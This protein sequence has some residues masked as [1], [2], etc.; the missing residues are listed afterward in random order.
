MELSI[1]VPVYNEEKTLPLLLDL[2]VALPVDKEIIT[3]DDGSSDASPMIL[4]Q[5]ADAGKIISLSHPLNRGKGASIITGVAAASGE[6]SVVQD[7]DLEYDPNDLL[8][9]LKVARR[10]KADVVFGSRIHNPQAGIS[11]R[12]YY[13]G[14][15]L[16]TFLANLLFRV[17]IS[18]ESTCYKMVRTDLLK[19]LNLKC[20][21]FEF[22]PE[23]VAKLGRRKVPIIEIPISYRPRKMEEGKKIR[24]HDG[25]VAIW[26]LI[27]YRILP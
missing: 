18:D 7:A 2:L 1:L 12:R 11:Y 14:G 24:W 8:E 19:S 10:Q 5:Y 21:R 20:Q 25:A 17:H 4:K 22:C 16:L 13:Y 6:Y 3:I 15:K 26:T 23:L 9:M 27:K